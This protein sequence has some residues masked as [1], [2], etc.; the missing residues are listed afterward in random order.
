MRA[1]EWVLLALGAWLAS[2][3]LLS[4]TTI[5]HWY[6]RG[7]DFP[8]L[9]VLVLAAVA[10]SAH[11]ALFWEGR[12]V[13]QVMAA[14]MAG[15]AAW[16]LAKVLPYTPLWRRQVVS[17]R[18]AD[19]SGRLRVV[20]SNVLMENRDHA[21]WLSVV[22]AADPDVIVA[23]ET[24]ATW[25][26]A[27]R[28]LRSSYPHVVERVLD[29][30]YGMTV[31]SRLP[32]VAPEVRFLV[33]DGVPSV[34]TR[35]RLRNGA[36]VWLHALHPRPPEPDS[37]QDSGPRDAELVLMA[38]EIGEAGGDEPR[39]VAGDLNDVAWSYTTQLFLRLSHMLDPRRGRGLYNTFDARKPRFLRWPLDHVFHTAHFELVELCLLP[40]V[41]SD[42]RPVSIDLALTPR[43][44]VVQDPP[45]P[46]PG[47]QALAAEL[48]AR[49]A[50]DQRPPVRA[51]GAGDRVASGPLEGT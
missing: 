23:L 50:P 39:I 11:A 16:Q 14:S 7:W 30:Y 37:G 36:A 42:H 33:E 13:D 9:V 41:G 18:A 44:E 27:L 10:G 26:Q 35:V 5:P 47:D 40:D 19:P 3:T 49:E 6:V 22:R 48:I 2:G 43:A 1:L 20:V 21:R 15:V 24:D 8:R 25:A 31:L 12:A 17:A 29:N 4:L 51:A 46:A 38:R 28:P 45:D 34:H 32:L